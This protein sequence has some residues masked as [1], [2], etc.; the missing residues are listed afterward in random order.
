MEVLAR[1]AA[2]L[3]RIQDTG[4]VLETICARTRLLI[5]SDMAYISLNDDDTGETYIRATDGVKT[6]QYRSI[7]MPLGTG[8]LGA[9]ASGERTFTTPDYEKDTTLI[10]VPKI[11]DAVATEGVRSILAA[12]LRID[13]KVIG[14]LL[15][16][17]R[18]PGNYGAEE[19]LIIEALAPQ[20]AVAVENARLFET[21][22]TALERE[23]IALSEASRHLAQM[24]RLAQA[25]HAF[26]N[27]LSKPNGLEVL[28]EELC[29]SLCAEA[30]AFDA[31]G[32]VIAG[33]STN[34]D[35]VERIILTTI[36]SGNPVAQGGDTEIALASAQ[37][38]TLGGFVVTPIA[39]RSSTVRDADADSIILNRAC[40]HLS[41]LLLF[42]RT[43]DESRFRLERDLMSALTALTYGESTRSL[44]QSLLKLSAGSPV[45]PH[46]R[47]IFVLDVEQHL[48]VHTLQS[49]R[50]KGL[51]AVAASHEGHICGIFHGKDV[52][53]EDLAE[54]LSVTGSGFVGGIAAFQ[55]LGDASRAHRE[56]TQLSQAARK[57]GRA[58]EIVTRGRLGTAGLL[59]GGADDG[60]VSSIIAEQIGSLSAYDAQHG[61]A[62]VETCEAWLESGRSVIEAA[63]HLFVHTNTVRQRLDRIT[64]V[65]GAGWADGSHTLDLHLAIR[66]KRL[67]DPVVA[68]ASR[69]A[70]ETPGRLPAGD[71][72]GSPRSS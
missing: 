2:D 39:E 32:Q 67:T 36:G 72:G 17:N 35:A 53:A 29:S 23:R 9:A 37:G 56:A 16:A 41:A 11:D 70:G 47:A 7:R 62:L 10:H 14:A 13:G 66:L 48:H 58:K 54:A 31:T 30:V 61:T 40:S 69:Q 71:Q 27:A 8:V 65:L 46:A 64:G 55:E 33:V 63:E 52:T 51:A 34:H 12:P 45:P 22:R 43:L 44:E 26:S 19:Q 28:T 21:Q 20:A 50:D 24:R 68:R 38:A 25:E 5:D 4:Q 57:L 1:T 60:L 15:V 49:L 6:E 18:T 42:Q 3:T 59:V